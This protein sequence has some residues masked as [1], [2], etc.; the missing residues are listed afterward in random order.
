MDKPKIS[1]ITV[2]FNAEKYI[3][4][5][6]KSVI[7]QTYPNIEYI[8][9]D[10]ASKDGTIDIVKKY[11]S[12]I[13]YFLSEPDKSHFDAMNKGLAKATGDYVLYMNA[14]DRIKNETSLEEMM[15]GSD[16][17]DFIYSKSMYIDEEGN[18]RPWHKKTPPP[19][20]INVKSFING[21]VVCHHCIIV[22]REIAPFFNLE[23]WKVSND[24]DWA[25]RIM[26]KVKT[27]HFYDDI[28]CLYL[29]GGISAKQ[30]NKAAKERFDITRL[31]FGLFPTILEQFKIT[32]QIIKRGDLS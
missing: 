29:E 26:K 16:M 11:E 27:V 13:D 15:E 5:T 28:F 10:G 31:H 25:I 24:L 20:K 4:R 23:P 3:E 2:S 9:I 18:Q 14:G 7:C 19:D 6:I 8:V 12:E 1:I 32:F 17:A 21:M 22:K 30:R